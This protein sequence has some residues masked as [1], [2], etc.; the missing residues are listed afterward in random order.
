[1]STAKFVLLLLPGFLKPRQSSQVSREQSENPANIRLDEDV[2][3][4][5]WSRRIYSP[6]CPFC[7]KDFISANRWHSVGGFLYKISFCPAAD[8][9][10]LEIIS[11]LYCFMRSAPRCSSRSCSHSVIFYPAADTVSLK[12]DITNRWLE[13]TKFGVFWSFQERCVLLY[14]QQA[15]HIHQ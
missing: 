7:L 14:C 6:Y 15:A 2:F 10:S 1:M 9:V 8:K 12:I 13:D 4:K 11:L 5:S 3:K